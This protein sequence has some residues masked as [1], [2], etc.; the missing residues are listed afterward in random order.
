MPD[1][2]FEEMEM[3]DYRKLDVWNTSR[4]LATEVY[5]ASTNMPARDR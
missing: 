4:R 3:G 2:D 1:L 5:M